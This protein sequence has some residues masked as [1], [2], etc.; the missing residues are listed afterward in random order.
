[1]EPTETPTE[2]AEQGPDSPLDLD[3]LDPVVQA[4]AQAAQAWLARLGEAMRPEDQVMSLPYGDVDAAAAAV[5]DPQLYERAVARAGTTLPDFDVTTTPA[6]SS[7]SGYLSAQG[8]RSAVPDSTILVTD[9]MFEAPAPALAETEGRTVVVTSSATAEGGPGPGS[10]TSTTSMRQR[11]LS[12]AAVRFLRGDHA[13]LTM[14]VPHDWNPSDGSSE[15]FSGLDA[16]WL[17]LTSVQAVTRAAVPTPVPGATLH[18]PK[19]QAAAQLD[20]PNFDSADK[21]IRSGVTLQN[22][23]TLNNLVAGTVED[24]AF[25]TVSYYARTRPIENR[26]S[27]DGSRLWIESRLRRVHI[28]APRAVT[29]SSSSGRFQATVTNDLDQPVTVAIGARADD[30]L[31]IDGPRRIEVGAKRRVAV[32]LTARTN[33]NGIHP[34]VLVV[35]DKRGAPLGATTSLTVR[36]AQVSNVIW[37][38]IGVGCALLFGAIGVRLFRRV[39]NARRAPQES[40]DSPDGDGAEPTDHQQP[41]GAA[42]R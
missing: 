40:R 29:L 19:W 3:E 13:P 18:Y 2:E 9:A 32:L 41:A 23:L 15:F 8:I 38:F 24:E 27:A 26:A 11:L 30:R 42:T 12:E 39:R 6:L 25:G 17:D 33:E 4:A 16:A 20:K 36:S 1:V 34:V 22:L 21:L 28:E 37:L 14:V 35:N 7:P 10:R 5:H 31:A